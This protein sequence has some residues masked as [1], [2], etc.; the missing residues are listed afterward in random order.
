M[1]MKIVLP[2]SPPPISYFGTSARIYAMCVSVY[3]RV[4][5]SLLC[6]GGMEV[7]GDNWRYGKG[8]GRLFFNN[9]YS[10]EKERERERW[11]MGKRREVLGG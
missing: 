6:T 1:K 9:G 11:K 5:V 2:V 7:Y 4:E 8:L 3:W 10:I